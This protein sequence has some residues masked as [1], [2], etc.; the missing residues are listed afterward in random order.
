MELGQVNAAEFGVRLRPSSSTTS[1]PSRI[2]AAKVSVSPV[3]RLGEVASPST[4]DVTSPAAGQQDYVINLPDQHD[5]NNPSDIINPPAGPGDDVTYLS[6]DRL[7][8]PSRQDDI[9]PSAISR[10]DAPVSVVVASSKQNH[11]LSDPKSADEG[12]LSVPNDLPS[13]TLFPDVPELS[14]GPPTNFTDASPLHA[15][16]DVLFFDEVETHL[17][18]NS[19]KAQNSST[20]TKHT[21]YDVKYPDVDLRT[22]FKEYAQREGVNIDDEGESGGGINGTGSTLT[23]PSEQ[24][25]SSNTGILS[26]TVGEELS[27]ATILVQEQSKASEVAPQAA[28]NETEL[29]TIREGGDNRSQ[30]ALSMEENKDSSEWLG[31]RTVE[32]EQ[33]IK[34]YLSPN[35]SLGH[36]SRQTDSLASNRKTNVNTPT[37]YATTLRD[38]PGPTHLPN[39]HTYLTPVVVNNKPKDFAYAAEKH[40]QHHTVIFNK[41]FEGDVDGSGSGYI[42]KR[43]GG[44]QL[45]YA[46]SAPIVDDGVLHVYEGERFP[47]SQITIPCTGCQSKLRLTTVAGDKPTNYAIDDVPLP[48]ERV[49][50]GLGKAGTGNRFIIPVRADNLHEVYVGGHSVGNADDRET[51]SFFQNYSPRGDSNLKVIEEPRVGRS[52]NMTDSRKSVN[53]SGSYETKGPVGHLNLPDNYR[54]FTFTGH[55]PPTIG[56]ST[57]YLPLPGSNGFL[58]AAYSNHPR[59][60]NPY[61]TSLSGH[62]R[63]YGHLSRNTRLKRNSMTQNGEKHLWPLTTN[64][65]QPQKTKNNKPSSSRRKRENNSRSLLPNWGQHADR[66]YATWL[67]SPAKSIALNRRRRATFQKVKFQVERRPVTPTPRSPPTLGQLTRGQRYTVLNDIHANIRQLRRM[68]TPTT[69]PD[70]TTTTDSNQELREQTLKMIRNLQGEKMAAV[71]SRSAEYKAALTAQ[72]KKQLQL[73]PSIPS[74]EDRWPMTEVEKVLEHL[75]ETLISED[76]QFVNQSKMVSENISFP[77]G[78]EQSAEQ[79]IP[80]AKLKIHATPDSLNQINNASGHL[81]NEVEKRKPS[82]MVS[83]ETETESQAVVNESVI[84]A[85]EHTDK[86]RKRHREIKKAERNAE[87]ALQLK[88][89]LLRES[90]TRKPLSNLDE[91]DHH[92][93]PIVTGQMKYNPSNTSTR[94]PLDIA[95]DQDTAIESVTNSPQNNQLNINDLHNFGKALRIFQNS[96]YVTNKSSSELP[97]ISAPTSQGIDNMHN[98]IHV[99]APEDYVRHVIL[100][101]AMS[102]GTFVHVT[103][104]ERTIPAGFQTSEELDEP[105]TRYP[106]NSELVLP[107]IVNAPIDLNL[108]EEDGD[109]YTDDK[110]DLRTDFDNLVSSENFVT[111]AKNRPSPSLRNDSNIEST[112]DSNKHFPSKGGRLAADV[113]PIDNLPDTHDESTHKTHNVP[114]SQNTPSPVLVK[115]KTKQQTS[116]LPVAAAGTYRARHPLVHTRRPPASAS[117]QRLKEVGFPGARPGTGRR[118]RPGVNPVPPDV[119][120]DFDITQDQ[121]SSNSVVGGAVGPEQLSEDFFNPK[122]IQDS[123]LRTGPLPADPF[124]GA[125][126]RPHPG[127]RPTHLGRPGAFH[128]HAPGRRPGYRRRPPP[129]RPPQGFFRRMY[130]R[131]MH[132]FQ[133]MMSGP[134]R[135]SRQRPVERPRRGQYGAYRSRG[136]GGMGALLGVYRPEKT[137]SKDQS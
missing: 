69:Q 124:R 20:H 93:M 6:A 126:P 130:H 99:G 132:S 115:T 46:N 81:A 72:L 49:H 39:R 134:G 88:E 108:N 13:Q 78:V 76:A 2:P 70:I 95:T 80:E 42:S 125:Q 52:S 32:D 100:H 136:M 61:T 23:N 67:N 45:T 59:N 3:S 112:L 90:E 54:Y 120:I 1:R 127:T 57:Y 22:L 75:S 15:G 96:H 30:N 31:G 83:N 86:F 11:S 35:T 92:A 129:P 44:G 34:G 71:R 104:V 5:D 101:N 55:I 21:E 47:P 122:D 77:E 38:K 128:S 63:R 24:T 135:Y 117:E 91:L 33:K 10:Y 25:D 89:K 62:I 84:S 119:P 74:N 48:G 9:L 103:E 53:I 111:D 56:D 27:N 58:P 118:P 37:S 16:H 19:S 50:S 73:S 98:Y 87:L 105:T 107:N 97:S 26:R 110:T 18:G 28:F 29:K 60:T 114:K 113:K 131:M 133:H 121:S 68:Q 40:P 109:L 102:D 12:Q 116:K 43:T 14:V 7:E 36:G 4:S 94:S 79:S 17:A 8:Q 106:F 137:D 85:N 123:D 82:N 66:R 51:G 64:K 65:L 41:R